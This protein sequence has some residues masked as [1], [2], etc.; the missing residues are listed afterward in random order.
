MPNSKT[1]AEKILDSAEALFADSGYDAVSV[2]AITK[3]AGVELALVNYHFGSKQELFYRV[4][5]RRAAEINAERVRL[6]NEQS[7]RHSVESIIDAFTRPFLEKSLLGGGWKS[8]ARLIAQV[9]NSPRWTKLVMS[10]QFD[11]IAQAF[12]DQMCSALPGS[13]LE[14]IYWGFHFLLGA[15]TFTFAETGRVD[16]L[17][18]GLCRSGDLVIIHAKMVPFLAAG[19]REICLSRGAKQ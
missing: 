13:K 2:R 10:T 6:L 4:V 8:Y 11:P 18:D 5:E 17:S 15:V 9:S 19:F 7:E 12:V 1:T 14:D 3:R 16:E